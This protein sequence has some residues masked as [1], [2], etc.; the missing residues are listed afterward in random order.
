MSAEA[1]P[2]AIISG[3]NDISIATVRA[4]QRLGLEETVALVGFDEVPLA[5][6]IRPGLTVIAQDPDA[7]GELAA[8]RLLARIR[9]EELPAEHVTVPTRLIARGSGEIRPPAR[10]ADDGLAAQAS[11]AS[12][13]GSPL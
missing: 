5:D 2:T 3:R 13:I 11:G 12:G 1:P 4:L 7:M 8:R 6:L 10:Q 9:G